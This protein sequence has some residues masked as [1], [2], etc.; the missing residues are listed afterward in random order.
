[1][2]IGKEALESLQEA[3]ENRLVK[4]FEAAQLLAIHAKRQE[5][6]QED[7]KM[8]EKLMEIFNQM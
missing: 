5:I 3:A 4:T 2:R 6:Q 8:V 7:M 1:M